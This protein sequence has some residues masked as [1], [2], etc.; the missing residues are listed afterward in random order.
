MLAVVS[1]PVPLCR[2]VRAT[3]MVLG[4]QVHIINTNLS[5]CVCCVNLKLHAIF[6]NKCFRDTQIEQTFANAVRM[7]SGGDRRHATNNPCA[8]AFTC[9]GICR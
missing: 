6:L 3:L 2:D 7:L 4:S 9:R 8:F 1:E 5:V